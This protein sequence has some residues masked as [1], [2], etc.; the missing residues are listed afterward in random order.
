[1][2]VRIANSVGQIVQNLEKSRWSAG[3]H[4]FR[5]DASNYASGVYFVMLD[6]D[7]NRQVHKMLLLK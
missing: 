6:T 7:N 5:F 1:V 4:T 3:T 2:S